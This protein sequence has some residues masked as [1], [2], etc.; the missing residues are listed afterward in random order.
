MDQENKKHREKAKKRKN[1]TV[2]E[3][4]KFVRRRDP[5]VIKEKERLEK[6]KEEKSIRAEARRIEE[7]ERRMEE[8]VLYEE[9]RRNDSEAL[10]EAEELAALEAQFD[11][12]EFEEK[13]K[14]KGKKG[15][16]KNKYTCDTEDELPNE[17]LGIGVKTIE[18]EQEDGEKVE[19]VSPE[20]TKKKKKKKKRVN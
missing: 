2:R 13:P 14:K 20:R 6:E 15:K 5:R 17:E 16:N 1:D 10:R 3:L 19:E 12:D 18:P 7:L 9:R 11:S 8:A 4:V